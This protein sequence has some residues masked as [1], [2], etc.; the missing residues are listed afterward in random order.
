MK[1]ACEFF[2]DFLVKD[3]KTG[4]LVST[5]SH[6]P[7]QGGTVAGPTMDHQLIRA[8]FDI[9]SETC[10]ILDTDHAFAAKVAE[11]RRQLA[12]EQVGS[13]G[14][15]Q[16]WLTDIDKPNDNHRHMSPLWCVYPGAQYTPF[17]SDPK[18]F[19]AAKLL[20]KWRG[21]GTTGWSFA[22]RIPLWARVLDGDYALSQLNGLLDKRTLPNLFDLC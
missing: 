9:T 5:P 16:E 14:Q 13:H 18:L 7:E 21:A 4:W 11:A 10:R 20:L 2:L 19:N 3:E 15:L 6:S 17:D 12:A 22:W 8:L 1:E